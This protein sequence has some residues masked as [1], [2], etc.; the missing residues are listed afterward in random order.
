MA[1]LDWVA[2][3]LGTGLGL[4]LGFLV[5]GPLLGLQ[6]RWAE[7]SGIAA[8]PDGMPAAALGFQVAGLALLALVVGVT[9]TTGALGAAIVAILAVAA[10]AGSVGAWAQK[11]G[12]AIAVDVG[13]AL[14]AGA[15][16][17]LA[18]GLL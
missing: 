11:S 4:G 16:M 13:Y 1:D 17:I 14:G 2:I 7:G 3:L 15:L 18:Q 12:F 8:A 9:E 10:W 6:R 5:Y